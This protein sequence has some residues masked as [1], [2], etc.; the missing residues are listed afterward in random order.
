MCVIEKMENNPYFPDP[1]AALKK[2]KKAAPA[3]QAALANAMGRDIEMV[4]IKDKKKEVVLNLLQELVDYVTKISAGNKIII[5]SSGFDASK[6]RRK[7]WVDPS[8]KELE[9]KLGGPGTATIQ[10]KKVF[11]VKAYIHQYTSEP[12]GPNTTWVR[13]ESSVKNHTFK[14]LQSE[15]R[16]WFRVIGIGTRNRKSYSPIVSV[17]IQ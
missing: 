3:F 14:G 8:I 11:G 17:V 4:A 12:P 9:V 13:E 2:L 16:H 10:A 5:L 15:K 7:T 1:P 6:E